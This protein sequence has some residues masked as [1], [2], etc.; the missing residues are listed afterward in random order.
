MLPLSFPPRPLVSPTLPFSPSQCACSQRNHAYFSSCCCCCV[1]KRCYDC[2]CLVC[3]DIKQVCVGL[4]LISP[5]PSAT[6][7]ALHPAA[8]QIVSATPRQL[9]S[10]IRI[11]E[12]LARMQLAAA[13]SPAHVAEAV[14]LMRVSGWGRESRQLC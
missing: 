1:C 10:L 12:A 6:N 9:E 7:P 14:R 13:V 11:S 3:L 2:Q 5:M 4:P 8:L